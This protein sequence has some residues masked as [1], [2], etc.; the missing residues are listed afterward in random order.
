MK[1]IGLTRSIGMGKSFVANLFRESHIDVFDADATIHELTQAGGEAESLVLE[2]F[3][4]ADDGQGHINRAVL[5]MLVFSDEQKLR[6]LEKLLHPLVRKK[7][8]DFY[9]ECEQAGKKM[10]VQ[11]IPLLYETGADKTCH[12]VVVV[13]APEDIQA[14]RVLE[15]EHMTQEK[16]EQIKQ[17]QLA[18]EDKIKKADYVIYTDKDQDE[19]EESVRNIINE[20]AAM[21]VS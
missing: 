6:A 1:V 17:F 21:S 7:G 10:I 13:Y 8:D 11:D 16:Y 18:N 2:L 20:V 9:K 15:R 14:E 5:G 4:E 12:V 3:P 19:I